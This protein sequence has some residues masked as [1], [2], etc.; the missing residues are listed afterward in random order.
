MTLGPTAHV[1]TFAR[2]GLPP[3]ELSG[4]TCP[5]ASSPIPSAST[6]PSS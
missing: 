2:D 1:D 5:W 4:P 3:R 6:P